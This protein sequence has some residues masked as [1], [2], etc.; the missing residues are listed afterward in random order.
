M[1]RENRLYIV[2]GL[3]A[4][5]LL[6]FITPASAFD[7]RSGDNIVIQSDEVINDDLYVTAETFVLDGTVNGDVIATGQT[8]TINGTVDG[9]VMVAGQTI[10]IHGTVTGAVR[11]A[12]SVL[13]IDEQ[14]E[15]GGDVIAA[16]YSL[17]TREGSGIGQDLVFAGGQILLAGDVAR[18]VQVGA[19][20]FELR[21]AAGGDVNADVG[22]A[23]AGYAGPPPALFM[24]Q[25]P[26]PIPA[27]ALG[28]SVA[29]SAKIEGNLTYTQSKEVALPTGVV[30]GEVTRTQ[31]AANTAATRQET[32]GERILDWGIDTLRTSIT[33]ILIGLF[34]MW[35][36]PLFIQGL[37]LKLQSAPF[38][39]LGWGVAAYLIFFLALLLIIVII[40][41]A[42][43]LFGLLTLGGVAGTIISVGILSVFALILGFV[44]VTA[45]VAKI[46]FGQALGK[47]LLVRANSPLAQ[48]RFWPMIIGVLITV[49]VIAVFSFPLIPGFLGSLLN[50]V[51]VLLGLGALWLWGRERITQRPVTA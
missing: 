18:N 34:L 28:L 4:L 42:A 41:L 2:L 27:V 29:Q 30:T 36:F 14:A 21:G 17:E 32:T 44:L 6:I 12:G 25:S 23:D 13:L 9:D 43:L 33:L 50:F 16:G 10:V 19:G 37:S 3:L 22:E 45:F 11:M 49:V 15:V 48:H 26:I 35:L 40:V 7:G 39:S 24:P 38:P 8:L 5:L 31:P 51:V 20:A 46:V 47:W 1:N